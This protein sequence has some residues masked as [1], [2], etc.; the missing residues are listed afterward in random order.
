MKYIASCL[1]NN[2]SKVSYPFSDKIMC[3]IFGLSKKLEIEEKQKGISSIRYIRNW[4]ADGRK[5]NGIASRRTPNKFGTISF[6][7]N[8]TR[9]DI[10]NFWKN[11]INYW[12]PLSQESGQVIDTFVWNTGL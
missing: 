5:N 11:P 4:Q 12:I 2:G 9:M 8:R 10:E 6:F 3:N 1:H 7:T